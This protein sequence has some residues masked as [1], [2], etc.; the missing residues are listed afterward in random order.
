MF[1]LFLH[2]KLHTPT[3]LLLLSLAVSDFFVGI[4]LFFLIA[5]IIAL[6]SQAKIALSVH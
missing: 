2:R 4:F 1:L 6:L 5:H 3:N